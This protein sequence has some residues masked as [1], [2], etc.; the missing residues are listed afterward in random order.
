MVFANIVLFFL[1]LVVLISG[2]EVFVKKASSIAKSLGVSEFIIGLTL[3]AFGTSIP[4]L[5]SSGIAAYAKQSQ[6]VSGILVGSNMANIGL[7]IGICAVFFPMKTFKDMLS[8]GGLIMLFSASL[9]F[10]FVITGTLSRIE[11]GVLVLFYLAYIMYEFERSTKVKK[12]Y[13][14]FGFLLYFITFR[15]LAAIT[16]I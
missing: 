10:V 2:A 11:A 7:I 6:V 4:E 3:V 15:Y 13:D 1:G 5:A 16:R 12:K 9:F 8:K 14:F